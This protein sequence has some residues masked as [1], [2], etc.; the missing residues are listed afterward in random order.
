MRNRSRTA[1]G[2][3]PMA[4]LAVLFAFPLVFMLVSSLKPDEQIFADLESWRAFAPVGQV[5]LDNYS[6]VFQRVPAARFLFNSFLVSSCI[7]LFGLIV[8][9]L[10]GFA[11]A[12]VPWRWS[13]LLLTLVIATLILPFETIALPLLYWV[14]RLPWLEFDGMVPFVDTGWLNT[15]RVQIVPFIAN[16]FSIFLFRQHFVTIP[17]DLDDAARIDGCGWLGIYRR[18]AV[19]LS[20]PAFATVALLTF[21]P[22]WNSYLWPLMT[23]Q[24]E[25]LRPVLVGVQYFFQLD[26]AWGQIM[27][28]SSMITVPVLVLFV[29]FQRAFIASIATTGMK[30]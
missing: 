7:V 1:A 15:Y 28:Y 21:L 14:I 12:R 20:G 16:G 29:V 25:E 24:R 6:G 2:Y 26:I 23:V 22:A 8:N 17:R 4:L 11:L 30:G 3:L 9:S 19:P 13:R 27:A 5:S 18:V 10:A